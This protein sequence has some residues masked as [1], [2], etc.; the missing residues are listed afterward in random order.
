MMGLAAGDAL[1]TTVEFKAP[2]SFFPLTDMVGGGPFALEP[3]E[4]TDDTSMALCLADSLI[5]KQGFD[6]RDQMERYF[7]WYREGY[8]SSNGRSFDIGNTTRTALEKFE[9]TADPFS[10]PTGPRAA[11]NGSIM[12][13]APVPFCTPTFPRWPLNCP[14]KAPSQPMAPRPAS[15]P[16]G[17]LVGSSQVLSKVFPERTFFHRGI[18]RTG[19]PGI[20]KIWWK[21]FLKSHEGTYKYKEPPEIKGNRLCGKIAGSGTLGLLPFH[22]F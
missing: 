20:R 3:G 9:A 18:D 7:R 17:I 10:G 11:G 1:G 5:Q 19:A 22:F 16:A 15:M 12:R 14:E 8:M 2:G 21:R 6:P 13:L 4:W